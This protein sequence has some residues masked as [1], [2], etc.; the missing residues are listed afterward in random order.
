AAAPPPV[1]AAAPPPVPA[2][3]PP[4]PPV[5]E[6]SLPHASAP[7]PVP[8]A[9]PHAP[10]VAAPPPPPKAAKKAKQ[11]KQAQAERQEKKFKKAWYEEFFD[12]DFLRTL[13][14]MT[15]AS[16]IKEAGYISKRLELGP[17]QRV[18]DIGCG[19]GR[20]AI[21][22]AASKLQVTG[23]DI[24]LP[25]L[26]KAAE[27]T[28]GEGVE[29]DFLHQ[30]MREMT[31]TE[32][33]DGAYCVMTSFGYFDDEANEE[34]IHRVFKA[35][36][37]GARFLM[38]VINRDF[39]LGDLPSRVWWEGDECIVMDEVEFNFHTSRIISKRSVA[40]GD[41]HSI[42]H[43]LSIRAYSLHELSSLLLGVGFEV[44]S[45]TGSV[46]TPDR[47]F[48]QYSPYLIIVAKK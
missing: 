12:D 36:K 43:D 31:F 44:S 2:A 35:L 3:A 27:L 17:G 24:S 10:P 42:K 20:H 7:P 19:Y 32:E 23:I 1:P 30:D 14:F 37:P 39:V 18:L 22:L 34:V 28:R 6:A 26:I 8:A 40:F 41:G 11:S 47:F 33:F 4:P 46:S 21:E 48:G 25:L 15:R 45:V 9:A 5:A 38:E 16:C 29:V 13:P